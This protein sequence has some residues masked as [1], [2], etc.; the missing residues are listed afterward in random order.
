LEDADLDHATEVAL[1]GVF[2]NCGQNCIA[3]E[4]IYVHNKIL[5]KYTP[6]PNLL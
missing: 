6:T 5:P 1:R 3:A 2:V 4:R